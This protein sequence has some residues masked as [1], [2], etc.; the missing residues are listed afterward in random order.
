[1]SVVL[2]VDL[3]AFAANLA[4]IRAVLGDAQ[5]VL[6]VKDDAYA[7]GVGPIV[8]RAWA[9]GVRWFGAFD[10]ATGLAV[11]AALDG[12]PD[13]AAAR[14]FVWMLASRAEAVAAIRAGLDIGVGD[15][16]LL[17]D[18][19]AAHAPEVARV[20]LK[21]DTG[22]HRNGVRPEGWAAFVD[23]AL[24]HERAGA[25]R[26]VGVWSHLAEASDAEDDH[27]RA[28]FDAAASLLEG[29]FGRRVLRHL[30]ASAASFARPE[31]RYDLARI[32]AFAY[33][34]R[35]PGG[36]GEDA[37]GVYPIA[38]LEA[39]LDITRTGVASVPVGS[40]HGLPSTLRAFPVG[41]AGGRRMLTALGE[42][43]SVIESDGLAPG[44][45]VVLFGRGDD[46]EATATDLAETI[47]TVG[48]EIVLRVSPLVPRRYES[49]SPR[50]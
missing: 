5:H 8:R 7:H 20:H 17:E 21:I 3:D 15:A 24:V 30:S 23:R 16:A 35:P 41:T 11:R 44:D 48:E 12:E 9:E 34:I 2:R 4:R 42:T 29:R 19:A 26:V 28:A 43:R 13:A 39:T 49:V 45:R 37:L 14:V 40:L 47:G 36:P 25:V 33:G 31:F 10:L 22:L 32:G 18:V 38:R 46:G 6:V 50:R 27:A 1:M